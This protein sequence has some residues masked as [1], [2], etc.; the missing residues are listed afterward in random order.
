LA[1]AESF[2]WQQSTASIAA[3]I[4]ADNGRPSFR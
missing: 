3:F 2:G 1:V 4:L